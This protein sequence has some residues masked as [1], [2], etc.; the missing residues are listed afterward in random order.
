METL[1]MRLWT[2]M[3]T[4]G[5]IQITVLPVMGGNTKTAARKKDFAVIVVDRPTVLC[6]D[7]YQPFGEE[8]NKVLARE[9]RRPRTQTVTS[10]RR[11]PV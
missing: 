5:Q 10:H 9:N 1:Q 8:E 2:K 7:L 3:V 6:F 11:H 4:D